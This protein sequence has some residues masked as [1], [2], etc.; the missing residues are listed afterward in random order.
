MTTDIKEWIAAGRKYADAID[1]DRGF[2]SGLTDCLRGLSDALEALAGEVAFVKAQLAGTNKNIAG[3]LQARDDATKRA[4]AAEAERDR[5]AGEVERL[6]SD[7]N[8][9]GDNLEKVVAARDYFSEEVAGLKQSLIIMSDKRCDAVAERDRLKAA[10]EAF[11][12]HFGP[13]EDNAMLHEGARNCYRL[14]RKA[15][16]GDAS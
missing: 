2:D 5:L 8:A 7:V 14:A 1:K 10:L 12:K 15:L 16:G 3:W 9:L 6:T 4:E 13:L 11:V